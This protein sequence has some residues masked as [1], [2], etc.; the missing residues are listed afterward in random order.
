MPTP[1]PPGFEVRARPSPGLA[2][3][4]LVC[5]IVG[6]GALLLARAVDR[7]PPCSAR[8]PCRGPGRRRG[9]AAHTGG[10]SAGLILGIV[11]LV[12]FV[13]IVIGGALLGWYDD[14]VVS[15]FDLEVGQCVELDVDETEVGDLPLVD[16]DE[17]HQ[18]EV[19]R[20]R[21]RRR[22]DFP[23]DESIERQAQDACTGD[24][25][26]AY[27][28]EPYRTS[29]LEWFAVMP[30]ESSWRARRPRHRLPRRP[31]GRRRPRRQRPRLGRLSSS[32]CGSRQRGGLGADGPDP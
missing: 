9:R 11:G 27:V 21:R 17:P 5:G 2:T 16:C 10:R 18:A 30:T 22:R 23:G 8:S 19:L 31:S 15:S 25:F 3:A 32:I 14:D 20:R 28:G 12:L 7:W 1:P 24:A 29:P 13:G 4:A 26:E 6:R